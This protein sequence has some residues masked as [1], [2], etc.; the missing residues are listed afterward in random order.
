M[1]RRGREVATA[2][3]EKRKRG[4]SSS[5]REEE[6]NFSHSCA[7][8]FS[9]TS[10]LALSVERAFNNT[11]KNFYKDLILNCSSGQGDDLIH[12]FCTPVYLCLSSKGDDQACGF[13]TSVYHSLSGRESMSGLVDGIHGI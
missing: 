12:G 13:C 9:L 2:V 4:H 8:F 11:S 3:R 6:E 1:C 10:F 7:R 5:L